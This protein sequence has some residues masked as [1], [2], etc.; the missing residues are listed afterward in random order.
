MAAFGMESERVWNS[1][2]L[3]YLWEFAV[4]MTF[5]EKLS[6]G[7]DI[8][9]AA[10]ALLVSAIVGLSIAAVAMLK[11]FNDVP[12][13]V[14][15]G[16]LAMVIYALDWKWLNITVMFISRIFYELYLVHILVFSVVF[17]LLPVSGLMKYPVGLFAVFL[18]MGAAWLYN[19]VQGQLKQIR[20][21]N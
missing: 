21:H 15:Y 9:V 11:V 14:E 13:L 1:F 8:T 20:I 17:H 16:S 6:G 7:M 10:K 19:R 2:C 3:R 18:T 4:G 5:D 12:A